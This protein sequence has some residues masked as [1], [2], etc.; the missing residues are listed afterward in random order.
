MTQQ[1]RIVLASGSPRRRALLEALGIPVEVIVSDADEH[2]NGTPEQVATENACTKRDAVMT[3][4]GDDAIVIAADTIVVVDGDILCKP[5]DLDE[6]RA[7]I[8][9]LAGR[10]HQVVT[11]IAAGNTATDARCESHAVTNVTFRDLADA[12]IDA[13]VHAVKPLDRAGAYTVD[14]PGSLLVAR[15]DGCFYN[16]LGLPIVTLDTMLRGMGLNL[17]DLMNP[18]EATFL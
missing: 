15:Y 6:A 1:P 10:T 16:V 3:T 18:D 12:D 14:G 9:R 5:R 7:M 8:R 4:A 11:G 2:H 17:V 13:F